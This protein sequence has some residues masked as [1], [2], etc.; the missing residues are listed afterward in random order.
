MD[1]HRSYDAEHALRLKLTAVK[2]WGFI[3]AVIIAAMVVV[4]MGSISSVLLFLCT[5]CLVAYVASPLVT[6]LDEHKVPRGWAAICGVIV[7]TLGV[8]VLF[9]LLIPLFFSQMTDLLR[10]L[11]A[12]IGSMGRWFSGLESDNEILRQLSSYVDV[13]QVV[14]TVQG[15]LSKLVTTLLSA[16][17]NGVVPIVGNTAQVVF[18][19]FLGLVLAYWV[20][21]DYPK[22]NNEICRLLGP[23]RAGGY[24]LVLAVVSRSVGGYLRST[25]INSLI[26]GVLA[27]LGFMLAGHPYASIMGVLSG[28][29]N[30]IPVVGPTI[31]AAIATVVA[32]FYSPVMA[33]WT[34]VVSVLSQNITDNVIVPKINQSTMQIH[35]VM[36]LTALMLGSALLGTV[37][38]VVALPLC[39]V[40]KSLFVFYFEYKTGKQVV[41]LDG[42]LFRGEPHRDADGNPVPELDALGDAAGQLAQD[43]PET[44]ADAPGPEA[45]A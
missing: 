45:S 26:Q 21:R 28:V 18:T 36:S 43:L 10:D 12:R 14:G 16:I 3:G 33:F 9:A 37:G 25:V 11:P 8:V 40:A 6:W 5:G 31:S 17:G 38:M 20:A 7:V 23:E 35:P 30:L 15:M 44:G 29:L 1:K 22:I 39:A 4:A 27:G 13:A 32:L 19:V 42:A 24:R 2:I 41:A 34:I